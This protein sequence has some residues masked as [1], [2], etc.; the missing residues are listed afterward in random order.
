MVPELKRLYANYLDDPNHLIAVTARAN[1]SKGARGPE[2]W[3]PPDRSYWC[4]YAVDWTTIKHKWDLTATP[5]EFAALDGM[6]NTCDATHL[7]G[8]AVTFEK[9]NLPTFGGSTPPPTPTAG[10]LDG[11][12]DSC[13]DAQSAGEPRVLGSQGSGRGFPKA[14][15]P[16]ARHGD[17]D[18]VVCER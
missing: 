3:K 14:M 11:R 15:V 18:G 9:P 13:E 6:L 1:R 8:V 17:G 10:R 2:E 4:R 5:A 7:L 12:Y 16:S